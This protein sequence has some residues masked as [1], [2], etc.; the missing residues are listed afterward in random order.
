LDRFISERELFEAKNLARVVEHIDNKSQENDLTLEWICLLHQMLLANIRDEV[1]GR[2]R[3]MNEHVRVG[4]YI[5]PA[6][7]QIKFLLIKLLT[8]YKALNERHIVLRIARFHLEFEHIHPFVDGNGRVGR[9]LNN[10]LLIREGYVPINIKFV[11]RKIYYAAFQEYDVVGKTALMENIIGRAL[12]NS[13]HKRIAYLMEK[14]IITLAEY[15]KRNKLSYS[16]LLNKASRQ[17]IA[18]FLEK[19]IWKIGE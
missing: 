10:Y 4:S 16:N 15:A 12:M 9:L 17:T 2:F 13:Y 6:P 8:D 11:E 1:A 7:D 18:A 14:N 3:I 19:G 5:A